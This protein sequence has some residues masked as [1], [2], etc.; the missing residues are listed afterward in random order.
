MKGKIV[1]LVA[2]LTI[3]W[4]G[5]RLFAQN[6]RDVV[7]GI[8]VNY[9]EVKAGSYS[10][11]DPLITA[12]GI[13]IKR[14]Q[15]WLKK[16]RPEILRM[17]EEEQFGRVPGKP[18]DLSFRVFDRGTPVL[19][20]KAI[21]KQ[22]TIYFTS[23]T[24]SSYKTDLLLY[25][26]AA[27]KKPAPLL[28]NISFT[29]NIA[30]ANDQGVKPGM[31]WSKEGKRVAPTRINTPGFNLEEL[32]NAGFGFATLCYTDIEPDMPQGILYGIRGKY[33][34]QGATQPASDEWGAISAWSWGLSR[35]MDYLET[36]SLIDAHRVAL[37]GA[38]RLGK[39][40]LWTGAR[41]SR[42]ALI[43]ASIS[44]EGGAA[45]SRR[46][47]GETIAHL[48]APARYPYQFAANYGKYA[49]HVNEMPFDSHMLVSLIAPRPLLLQ[50][51]NTDNWSDP[52]GEFLAAQAASPVYRLFGK[53]G[54]AGKA[55]PAANDP[56]LLLNPLGYYMHEGGHT[57]LPADWAQFILFMKRYL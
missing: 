4:F 31:V 15:D 1:S 43:I 25:L 26:P 36:D 20:G 6:S 24:A 28:L 17:F 7:A 21:R 50:T 53:D 35:V 22:A 23:N 55:M 54:P 2:L 34:T 48:T 32:I 40:V 8:P 46:N 9:D 30:L 47:F 39:T 41:D 10:L 27:S 5:Q 57:V 52:K 3:C 38:S 12:R 29:P 16:R 45:L 33:L 13:R 19:N 37:T 14:A 56:V 18:A 51:G 49:E 42:F 44:G 11:P